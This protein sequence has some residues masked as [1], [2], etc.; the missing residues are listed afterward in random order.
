MRVYPFELYMFVSIRSIPMYALDAYR[1]HIVVIVV[2]VR[3]LTVILAW[4]HLGRFFLGSS[5]CSLSSYECGF[6][7]DDGAVKETSQG[8]IHMRA[9][10]IRTL[11]RATG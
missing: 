10:T 8:S 4:M 3:P 11:T 1:Y 2:R 5:R 9:L 7:H 6:G